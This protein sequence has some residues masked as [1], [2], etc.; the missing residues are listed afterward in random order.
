MNRLL[1]AGTLAL[2]A[3]ST[4]QADTPPTYYGRW[5]AM[6]SDNG[7]FATPRGIGVNPWGDVYVADY[8]NQ[9]V[10]RF[11]AL[12]AF[13]TA[14]GSF[15]SDTSQFIGPW[16]IAISKT[17]NVYVAEGAQ[18]R[19]QEFT[20][21]GVF[22][23]VWGTGGTAIG[24]F[25]TPTGIAIG[26]NGG[27]YVT[28]RANNRVQEFDLNGGFIRSWGSQGSGDGQFIVP[29]GITVGN[30]GAVYVCD[31]FNDRIQ[32][33]DSTG[34]FLSKWDWS[35]IGTPNDIAT[36][37][38]GNLLVTDQANHR[39]VKLDTSGNVL[40]TFGSSGN[41]PGQFDTPEN[42]AV[43]P[44]GF[45]YVS[46][47]AL[48]LVSLFAP[49]GVSAPPNRPGGFAVLGSIPNPARGAGKIRFELPAA[50]SVTAG[51]YD[52]SGRLV[53]PLCEN[54]LQSAGTHDLSWDGRGLAAG[55]YH[56]VVQSGSFSSAKKIVVL[57]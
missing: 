21:D 47:S 57:E 38:Q 14:W 9:R 37:P 16:D 49:A 39:V 10:Q 8:N 11:T 4:A 43:S 45:I 48:N 5:G 12:G 13:D 53:R 17:G 52:V 26:P 27:V 56:V 42:V 41:G 6:G 25:S 15:G 7:Q 31:W 51:I 3:C 54:L 33:F 22:V 20:K 55:I 29:R 44:Y 2:L 18:Q 19:V 35:L 40:T 30:D 32:K 36:D 34:A 28:E 50:A 23:R 24:Q 1:L 46:D